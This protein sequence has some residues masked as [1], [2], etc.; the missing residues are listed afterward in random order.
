MG[1]GLALM[2]ISAVAGAAPLVYALRV[3][4]LACPFCAYRLKKQ[5]SARASYK[6]RLTSRR[7]WS[8]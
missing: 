8:P 5:I 2:M 7:A 3:D 6:S 1:L 4:G